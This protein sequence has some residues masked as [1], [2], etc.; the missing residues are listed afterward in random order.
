M[1]R[2][3]EEESFV[4]RDGNSRWATLKIIRGAYGN[5]EHHL[6]RSTTRKRSLEFAGG[7]LSDVYPAE[8]A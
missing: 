2:D 5:Y 1:T 7:K 4:E 6:S 8:Y 3:G